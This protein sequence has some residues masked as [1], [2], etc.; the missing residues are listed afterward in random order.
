MHTLDVRILRLWGQSRTLDAPFCCCLPSSLATESPAEPGAKP[1]ASKPQESSC[2]LPLTALRL[3]PHGPCPAFYRDQTRVFLLAHRKLCKL[4]HHSS[5][6]HSAL[7]FVWFACLFV[8][9]VDW[10]VGFLFSR[11][12]FLLSLG[13][14]GT[15][16]VGQVGLKFTEVYLPLLPE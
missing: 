1:A 14:P 16:F 2:A 11:Q 6:S 7:S 15:S 4:S 13:C 8:W 10:L 5:P 3:Q 12:D 9:M